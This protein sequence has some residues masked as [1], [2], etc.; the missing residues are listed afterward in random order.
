MNLVNELKDA[1]FFKYVEDEKV[2]EFITNE[3]T[4]I[5]E[6]EKMIYFPDKSSYYEAIL[7]QRCSDNHSIDFRSCEAD[8]EGLFRGGL[9]EGLEKIKKLFEKRNFKFDFENEKLEWKEANRTYIIH[10]IDI[11]GKTYLIADGDYNRGSGAVHYIRKVESIINEQLSL[12][13]STES[14]YKIASYYGEVIWYVLM[15]EEHLT[16]FKRNINEFPASQLI[17]E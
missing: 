14:A 4:T 16:I 6:N 9:L 8:G 12:Q 1:D 10:E 15:E 5:L 13:G 2:V 3:M 11:N 17:L 7:K